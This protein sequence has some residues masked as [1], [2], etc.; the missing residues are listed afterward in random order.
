VLYFPAFTLTMCQCATKKMSCFINLW[1]PLNCFV[2]I[3]FCRTKLSLQGEIMIGKALLPCMS[4]LVDDFAFHPSYFLDIS[5]LIR[6]HIGEM[7]VNVSAY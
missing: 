5:L 1:S 4:K 6:E 3:L 7:V 2:N